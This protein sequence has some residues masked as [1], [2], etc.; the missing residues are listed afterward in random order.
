V[1]LTYLAA[2]APA[3]NDTQAGVLGF[4]IVAGIGI[5]L[6]FLLISM[7]KQFKK[8]GPKPE[9]ED[10]LP[11]PDD[12]MPHPKGVVRAEVVARDTAAKPSK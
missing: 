10:E 7:N 12:A 9:D 11:E 2:T 8:I 6:V 3:P 5:A 4:L 1:S